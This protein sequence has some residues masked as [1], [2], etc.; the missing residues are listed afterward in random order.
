MKKNKNNKINPL[1]IAFVTLI[2]FMALF[3]FFEVKRMENYITSSGKENMS[4]VIEQ[5]EQSYDLRVEG[6]YERLQRVEKNLFADKRKRSITLS[7]YQKFLNVMT[8]D[9]SEHI[10]FIKENGQIM[11]QDGN[12][13]YLDIQ[14]SSL[15]KLQM[16][17]RIAQS[18][19]WNVDSKKESS[20]LIALPCE[21]YFVYGNEFTAIGFLFERSKI[22]SLFDVSGYS[23]QA[24][25]FSVDENG[26]VTYTNQDGGQYYRNYSLLK[27]MRQGKA[28][29]EQEYE[30]L[31]EKLGAYQTGVMVLGGGKYYIGF[32]PIKTNKS[33]LVCIAPSS[34]LNNSLLAYQSIAVKTIVAGMLVLEVLCLVLF[35]LAS[36]TGQAVQKAKYE[37]E[38]RK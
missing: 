4:A 19:S 15:M 20:Y 3:S 38:T 23:G 7:E 33:E 28:I 9:S 21:P 16:K 34:V 2:V 6:I 17:E 32:C 14:S 29:T 27:H 37:E 30:I 12:E 11:S 26:I 25:L 5:M 31:E 24:L 18:V 36:K 10:V 13:S 35:Y 22:D 1:L 8:D